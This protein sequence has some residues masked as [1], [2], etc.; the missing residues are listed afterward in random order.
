LQIPFA[1]SVGV[2][3]VLH[4]GNQVFAPTNCDS[5][6]WK[7]RFY[8]QFEKSCVLDNQKVPETVGSDNRRNQQCWLGQISRLVEIY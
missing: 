4:S 6:I 3:Q 2:W 5:L 8:W 1:Q 7:L